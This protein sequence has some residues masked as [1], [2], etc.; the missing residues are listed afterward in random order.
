MEEEKLRILLK[1]A[2]K[3]NLT[4][5]AQM[6]GYTPSG[7]SRA[8]ASLEAEF[9]FPLLMRKHSGVELTEAG[10]RL[11]PEIREILYHQDMLRQK[12][13]EIA[14][15]TVGTVTIGT[16]YGSACSALQ[17]A[18]SK[19]R[20]DYPGITF[21]LTSGFTT[22]LHEML[23]RREL[24]LIV[25]GR[26]GD[27]GEWYPLMKSPVVAWVPADSRY[28][29][30]DAFSLADVEQAPYIDIYTGVDTDSK[31]I[32]ARHHIRPNIQM[33]AKD[34]Y[35]AFAMV[36]AGL[37]IAL[38]ERCNCVFQSPR[39]RILPVEPAE[40]VEIGIACLPELSPAGRKFLPLLRR[41]LEEEW[42]T[43]PFTV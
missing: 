37:G 5:A 19:F 3:G 30:Q 7:V 28:A 34:S 32:L 2:E 29:G 21:H 17:K 20:R 36:E 10:Q 12:A 35:I 40:N 15:L 42:T 13:E 39:V 33:T 8:I 14:G 41:T 25:S 9:G 18:V 22:A 1:A 26:R 23:A 38:N 6:L 16:A 27:G 11:M 31:R 43:L 24:S 4:A